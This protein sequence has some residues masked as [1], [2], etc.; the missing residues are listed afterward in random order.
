MDILTFKSKYSLIKAR[1]FIKSHRDGNTGVGHTFEQELGL[2]ENNIAGPDIEGNEL[3]TARRGKGGKQTLL[4]SFSIRGSF[5]KWSK[6]HAQ[7]SLDLLAALCCVAAARKVPS[8][9]M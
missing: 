9:A 2:Q 8:N 4:K 6:K 1:G 5:Q 3:K 7:L